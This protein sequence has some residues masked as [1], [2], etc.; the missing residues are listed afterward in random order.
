MQKLEDGQGKTKTLI[1]VL[2]NI[3]MG[4]YLLGVVLL[5]QELQEGDLFGQWMIQEV[6]ELILL[7]ILQNT[8]QDNKQKIMK[9]DGRADIGARKEKTK[10]MKEMLL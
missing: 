6:P 9:V 5:N 7:F 3:L 8:T 2:G 4:G 1:P 10:N